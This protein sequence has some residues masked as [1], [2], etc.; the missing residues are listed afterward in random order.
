MRDPD[1]TELIRIDEAQFLAE[2]V[3]QM[4]EGFVDDFGLVGHKKDDVTGGHIQSFGQS[5]L[6]CVGKELGNRRLPGIF[7]D[8]DPGHALGAINGDIFRQV[9]DFLA[10]KSAA[11]LGIERFDNAPIFDDIGKDLKIGLGDNVRQLPEFQPE[12]HVRFVQSEALN[13]FGIVEA[14]EG[15]LKFFVKR[16]FEQRSNKGLHWPP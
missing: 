2:M 1:E 9:V 12:A 4:P 6:F 10:G 7:L 3:A 5:G 13:R 8:L 16:I 14:L 11:V 15:R